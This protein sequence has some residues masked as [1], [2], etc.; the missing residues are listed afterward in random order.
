[1]TVRFDEAAKARQADGHWLASALGSSRDDTL[2]TFAP[3]ER[4]LDCLTVPQREALNPPLRELGHIEQRHSLRLRR[5]ALRLLMTRGTVFPPRAY[6]MDDI[7][8]RA[9]FLHYGLATAQPRYTSVLTTSPAA[10]SAP[11]VRPRT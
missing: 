10:S 11:T 1:M 4:A 6:C 7:A 5:G 8:S 3:V 2:A 9:P